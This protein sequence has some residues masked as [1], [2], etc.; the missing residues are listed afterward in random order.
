MLIAFRSTFLYLPKRSSLASQMPWVLQVSANRN[1]TY[2]MGMR[3]TTKKI[4]IRRLIRSDN[5]TLAAVMTT[6]PL[7]LFFRP[8]YPRPGTPGRG[9]GEGFSGGADIPVRHP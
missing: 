6:T 3:I 9:Q 5:G 2:P 7:Q 8:S 1:T 4:T